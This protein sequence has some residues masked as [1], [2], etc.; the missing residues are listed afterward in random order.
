[1]DKLFNYI[2]SPEITKLRKFSPKLKIAILASGEGSNFQELI[3]L[4][5]SNKFDI[6]I[7]I[8]ITDNSDAGCIIKANKSNIKYATSINIP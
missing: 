5:K 2:I 8:L 6:D 1:M 7:T 4:S 3:D